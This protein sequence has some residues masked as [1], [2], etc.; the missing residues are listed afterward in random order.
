MARPL[1]SRD[2]LGVRFAAEIVMRLS[3]APPFGEVLVHLPLVAQIESKRPVN[4]FE[5]HG[6]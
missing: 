6:R 2:E 5:G 4:L 3:D 1:Q